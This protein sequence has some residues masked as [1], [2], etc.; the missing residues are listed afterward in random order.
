MDSSSATAT[1]ADESF[2]VTVADTDEER[3]AAVELA[4]PL[5]PRTYRANIRQTDHMLVAWGDGE[6][7]GGLIMKVRTVEDKQIG[8]FSWIFTAAHARQQ[9]VASELVSEGCSYLSEQGCEMV[10]TDIEGFNSASTALFSSAGFT[11]TTSRELFGQ[12]GARG[13]V[14]VWITL[15]YQFDFGHFLWATSLPDG[16]ESKASASD[17]SE[18]IASATDGPRALALSWAM[19]ILAIWVAAA[20]VTAVPTFGVTGAQLLA[21]TGAGLLLFGVRYLPLWALTR[22]QPLEWRYRGWFNGVPISLALGAVLGIFFPTT[23]DRYPTRGTWRYTDELRRI[24]PA[25]ALSATLT[26][27]LVIVAAQAPELFP[28]LA[29]ASTA[30]G[31]LFVGISLLVVDLLFVLTPFQCYRGRRIYDWNRVV[32]VVLAGVTAVVISLTML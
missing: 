8:F 20:T 19:N 13:L 23:G 16:A 7:I 27:G 28:T 10:V 22:G 17:E 3:E 12:L 2:A 31:V 26:L 15:S 5:F 11:R 18:T 25:A 9:G 21:F 30:G 14:R 4:R 29:G 24:G 6:I 1:Q 32:W